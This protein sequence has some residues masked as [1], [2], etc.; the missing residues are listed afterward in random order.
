M[1]KSRFDMDTLAYSAHELAWLVPGRLLGGLLAPAIIVPA[2]WAALLTRSGLDALLVAAGKRLIAKGAHELLFVRTTPVTCTA[3]SDDLQ[4]ADGYAV[5]GSI[6][7]PIRILAE[8]SELSAFRKTIFQSGDSLAT[9]GLQRHLQ[10]ALRRA[11]EQLASSYAAAELQ[12]PLDAAIVQP[13]VEKE[14]APRCIA[15]G[16]S[17][18]GPTTVQF[19]SP[20]YREHCRRETEMNRRTQQAASAGQIQK[21]LAAAQE[22]HL[23]HLA[24]LMER[25]RDLQAGQPGTSF[26]DLLRSFSE[27]ER[28]QMYA[29]LWQL[30][31]ASRRTRWIAVASGAEVLLFQ[32]DNLRKPARRIRVPETLGPLRSLSMDERCREAGVLIA[33]AGVGVHLLDLETGSVRASLHGPVGASPKEVLGGINAAAMSDDRVFATHSELGLLAWPQPRGGE[34]PAAETLWPELTAHAQTVRCARVA[35]GRVWFAADE[36]VYSSLLGSE[37]HPTAYAGSESP[38]TALAVADDVVYAG[39]A[40]GELLAWQLDEPHAHRMLRPASGQSIE[41]IHVVNTGGIQR[42]IVA[43]RSRGLTELVIADRFS[44]AYESGSISVRRAAAAE[45]LLAAMNDNRDRLLVW[46]PRSAD[47]PAGIAIIPPLT[48]GSIQDL[49]L[50][51]A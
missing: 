50:I 11:L 1:L 22:A 9:A 15:A 32:P 51:P 31:G 7:V 45:D 24:H 4:S 5:R 47:A 34:S 43:D 3:D 21:V 25:L 10:P 26:Q 38:I 44:R 46:D 19:D 14:L 13:V 18:D 29:A 30:A 28:A 40:A 16:L 8:P 27:P 48:G 49:C 6:S 41:S 2:G 39:T 20:D 23:S 37:Q 12:K 42:L 33:G 35:E 36:M 17:I